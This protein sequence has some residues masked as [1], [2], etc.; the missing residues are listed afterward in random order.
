MEK[1][2]IFGLPHSGTTI[3]RTIIGHIPRVHTILEETCSPNH[4][5][6]SN[7][8]DYSV[9][10][11]P[12][13]KSDY[14]KEKYQDI[15]K[16]FIIRNPIF[17]LSSYNR[18]HNPDLSNHLFIENTTKCYLEAAYAYNYYQD[19][20]IN[21][22]YFIKYEDMF[23]EN[24]YKLKNLLLKIGLKFT[25]EIFDN[26]KYKNLS[27]KNQNIDQIPKNKPKDTDHEKLRLYQVNQEFKNYNSEILIEKNQLNIIMK[28]HNVKKIYPDLDSFVIV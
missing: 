14:F 17:F 27:H 23:I 21:R 20:N 19:K 7:A 10:K 28:D 9:F 25:D 3:L 26:K 22:L 11:Y 6:N 1:I 24:F 15:H 2:F 4:Q 12:I 16:I 18:R 13:L 5:L 8:Y